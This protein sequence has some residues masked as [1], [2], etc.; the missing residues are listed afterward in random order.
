MFRVHL[1][2]FGVC[3]CQPDDALLGCLAFGVSEILSP[4]QL[5]LVFA[6]GALAIAVLAALIR[7]GLKAAL[8]PLGH[9]LDVWRRAWFHPERELAYLVEAV[10]IVAFLDAFAYNYQV[11]LWG[12]ALVG[13]VWALHLPAD[14]WSWARARLRPASPRAL[15]LR[16]F[17]LL[18]LGPLWLRLVGLALVAAL[19]F[20]IPP[21][22]RTLTAATTYLLS[23]FYRLFS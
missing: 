17:R 22:R 6:A 15:H 4:I 12:A 16:G 1:N 20:L 19:Y 13:A 5:A 8:E 7:A 21:F 3:R 14:L 23:L 2:T 10:L 9:R 11:P 18:D